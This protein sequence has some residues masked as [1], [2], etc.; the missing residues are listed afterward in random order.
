MPAAAVANGRYLP[1]EEARAFARGLGLRSVTVWMAWSKAGNRPAN[2]PGNPAQAY[3]DRGWKG[4]SDWLGNKQAYRSFGDARAFARRLGFRSGADW[5]AWVKSGEKP[6]DIPAQPVDVYRDEGWAGWGDWLGTGNVAQADRVFRSFEDAR[7]YVRS[8]GLTSMHSWKAWAKSEDRPLDIPAAPHATYKNDGWQSFGDWIGTD[9]IAPQKRVYR[10]FDEAREFAR[11][12]GF[13]G[14][15]DWAE[16]SKTDS[17]PAD[18]PSSPGHV[19][20]KAGWSGW[21]DWLGTGNL[22]PGAISYRDFE[23]ARSYVHGL[24]LRN[25]ENW[26]K[27][28]QSGRRPS[29]IPAAPYAYY[30]GNGWH[31]WGDWLGTGFIANADREL[32]SYEDSR[33]IVR[34]LNLKSMEEFKAW[35]RSPERPLS[36]PSSPQNTYKGRGWVNAGDWLG[37][38]RV[39][40]AKKEYRSFTEARDFARSLKLGGQKDWVRWCAENGGITHIPNWPD[41]VYA[42]AGWSGWNDWLGTPPR[43]GHLVTYD[44]ARLLARDKGIRTQSEW[45]AWVRSGERPIG[46]PS[47]PDSAYASKGWVTWGEF[48]GKSSKTPGQRDFLPYEEAKILVRAAGLKSRTEWFAW[49]KAGHRPAGVPSSPEKTYRDD[50]W[51]SWGE[52]LGTGAISVRERSYLPFEAARSFARELGLKSRNEWVLWV[53]ENSLPN[54]IPGTPSAA[55]KGKGW[56]G[57]GDWLGTGWISNRLREYRNFE[58]ARLFA[59]S[60]DL[61]S[62]KEWREWAKTAA[63]PKD[64]PANPEGVFKDH[65]WCGWG[66]WLGT[67][68]IAVTQRVYRSFPDARAFAHALKL[69]SKDEWGLWAAGPEKPQD[70]PVAPDHVYRQSG[71]LGWGDWLGVANVWNRNAIL[72]FVRA[73]VPVLRYLDP[74]E[75]YAIMRQN[76]LIFAGGNSANSKR[77]L[78]GRILKLAS[79]PAGDAEQM[80][81]E[82]IDQIVET[83]PANPTEGPIDNDVL[84]THEEASA[85]LPGLRPADALKAVDSLASLYATADEEAIE[86]FIAKAVGKLWAIRLSDES[87][88]IEAETSGEAVGEYGRVVR[89]RFLAQLQGA[90]QMNL[91]AGYSFN[92]AGNLVQPNLMQRL[93][94]FRLL[95]EGRLGNWSGTGAGKTLAA[96]LASRVSNARLTVVIALNNTLEGWKRE[97]LTA[98]PDSTVIVKERGAIDVEAGKNTYLLLNFE[99]FQ[100]PYS[101]SMVRELAVR[102]QIDCIIIDEVHTAKQRGEKASKRRTVINGLLSLAAER[103]PE[104]RVLGMSA[105][106]VINDLVEAVSLLEMVTGVVFDELKTAPSVSNAIAVHEKLI[107]HGVRY[108]PIYEQVVETKCIEVSGGD[109]VR[110]LQEVKKGDVLAIESILLRAKIETILEHVKPGTLVYTHYVET[111]VP[112]L[113]RALSAA[114]HTFAE[115]TGEDKSGLERFKRREVDVLIGSSTIGTGVDGLQYVC[116]RLVVATLPWTSAGYEQLV[117]RIYRQGS[118]FRDI[119]VIVPQVVLQSEVERWSWDIQRWERILY[120]KTLAD[121]AVD[122]LIPEGNLAPPAVMLAQA[123]KALDSWIERVEAGTVHTIERSSLR[124]PLPEDVKSLV[125]RRFGD[126]SQMNARFNSSKSATNHERLKSQPEEWYLYHTLYREA[127]ARWSEVPY[128]VLAAWVSKRPDWIVGDFGC[129]EALLATDVPNKVYSFDHVAVSEHVVACDMANTGLEPELLDVAIFSLSLMGINVRDYLVEAYRLLRFGGYLKIAEPASRWP[130][131]EV[132]IDLI[133][134][135]G[136]QLLGRVKMR[137]QFVYVTALKG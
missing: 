123:K 23:T 73:L 50:G 44:E 49:V 41:R 28:A 83:T 74:A 6:A 12:L 122:G 95:S 65:G 26:R 116:D 101:A 14:Q 94:A 34:R 70:M 78:I 109:F 7:K 136:F 135:A 100:Q 66:D 84:P 62:G 1:F 137:A 58:D 85:D 97:V 47:N 89:E 19:Y 11:Q 69:S 130:D 29:D 54:D 10:N 133:E 31:S 80:L 77:H 9:S 104:L 35:A 52:W 129:G 4:W 71:W 55:Y 20:A 3:K 107:L 103:N 105:T 125:A 86:F 110:E 61:K 93:V 25:Q 111:I 64:I 43:R 96:I 92:I 82:I 115:F 53:R 8:L 132:L 40:N 127:R 38:L 36:I 72:S 81:T 102:H 15:K 46:I 120:K 68:Y 24:G 60:L 5:R 76:G 45:L 18:I 90:Q 118:K 79:L 87:I 59:R 42:K 67:G 56:Q 48:L 128:E 124:V 75:L 63:R 117:G 91:P 13:R 51:N 32:L 39:A 121:A 37:T 33:E 27:W 88:D 99:A 114:G 131:R 98:F 16:W 113:R 106:P 21:G 2:I 17:K 22:G 112:E 30:K 134:G 57:W 108:R 119:D 126:F